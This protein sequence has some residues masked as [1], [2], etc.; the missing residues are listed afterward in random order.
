MIVDKNKTAGGLKLHELPPQPVKELCETSRTVA[1]E[2]AVLLKNDNHVLPLKK[3]EKVSVFGRIQTDYY[4]SGT[5]SGGMVNVEFVTNILDSLR[6]DDGIIVNE[7]LASVY[8]EWI[9]EN[10]FDIGHGWATEPWCQ[11]EM[12]LDEKTVDDAATFSDTAIV[13]IG[14]TAG[15]SHDNSIEA[16]SILLTDAEGDMLDIVGKKFK[17]VVVLLNVGNIIDMNFI[18]E[19]HV[20]SVLYLWQGGMVGGDVAAELITGKTVPSGK[21]SD[22]I[23]YSFHD[24]P[25]K[26]NFGDPKRIFYKEDIYVGYRYFETFAKDKVMFPFG[27]GMSY[28]EFDV[29]VDEVSENDG[30]ITAKV[31]VKNTGEFN[32]KEVV[33]IYYGAPQGKLGNPLKQ[34]IAYKKTKLLKPDESETL[35]LS[36][37]VDDMASYDD[38][39]VTAH[40]SAYVLEQGD[41][42]IFIGT[43]VRSAKCSFTYT[44]DELRV[45]KQLTEALA[46]TMPF[47]RM[48]PKFENG[49]YTVEYED[50]PTRTV[51]LEKRIADNRPKDI[52]Y[53]GDK[54]IKLIDVVDGK[55]TMEQFVAQLTD[56][57]LAYLMHGEGMNSPKVTA[58][59][60]SAFGGVTDRL[61]DFGIPVACTTDGPSGIRMDSGAKA[62]AMPNGTC[63][64]CT[65]NDDLIELL[66]EYEGA[67]LFAYHIDALLGPGMNIHRDPRN[68]R[69]FEYFSE[70]P[71]LTG[72]MAAVTTMGIHKSGSTSTIKHFFGNNQEYCRA[73]TDS[74]M[75]ERAAREIY[76][77]GFEIAVKQGGSTCIMTSYNAV[78]GIWCMGN[79]DL[80]TTVL[81]GEWGF[82]GFVMSDWWSTA[83]LEG[84]KASREN[85]KAMV[86]AQNDV[87]MVCECAETY[88]DNIMS[89]LEEGFITRGELQRNAVNIFNYII[90]SP[91]FE[92]YV[93][94]GCKLEKIDLNDN[95]NAKVY[96]KF[97][98]IKNGDELHFK[99][100]IESTSYLQFT[101]SSDESAL[102]QIPVAAVLDGK[103]T[104]TFSFNGTEGKTMVVKRKLYTHSGEHTMKISIPDI[105]RIEKLEI[106][107]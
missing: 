2:G 56:R 62:T 93:L 107:M 46:P 38:S 68:G 13:V 12:P 75:S 40:K 77:K 65:W 51:D 83:N 103:D 47:K 27:F 58:G 6:K 70:D 17:K 102:S 19:Y 41:Y 96:A 26:D 60:G 87:Y 97:E 59:T 72:R 24:Y 20:D 69:N 95:P 71:Y 22:T 15:E 21:L 100:D 53:T 52:A 1:G 37:N 94:G 91:V 42:N 48:R 43:D 45:V 85:L 74:V 89:G 57:D 14:R 54:G 67:E 79:Y 5:G 106:K 23:A 31:S 39:G 99:A 4:K 55:A 61:I 50:A 28:T 81:R 30:V 33:Q 82:N 36:F 10:P 76:L 32:G 34:L 80:L 66:F 73:D 105:G 98:N 44:A 92:R 86:R 64:A 104:L 11:K 90:A 63:I 16:G 49:T 25:A 3:G 101:V 29:N 7:Q 88:E 35:T 9:K 84:E 78:N 8:E 18:N